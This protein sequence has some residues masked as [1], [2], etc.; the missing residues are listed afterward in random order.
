VP[1][2][3]S[4]EPSP[5]NPL[6]KRAKVS[7]ST[8]LNSARAALVV[9]PTKLSKMPSLL[10]STPTEPGIWTLLYLA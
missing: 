1:L 8:P 6:A 7:T 4:A 10:A 2:K 9:T 3:V 5:A